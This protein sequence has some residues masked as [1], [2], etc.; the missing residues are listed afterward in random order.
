M[1]TRAPALPS[2]RET[3]ALLADKTRLRL[4]LEL[5]AGERNV[6]DLM[7]AL[8]LPQPVSDHLMLLRE[9]G[10][11]VTRRDGKRV[12]YALGDGVT[13]TGGDG[14]VLACSGGASVSISGAPEAFA[15]TSSNA[16]ASVMW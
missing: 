10:T 8:S 6:S 2:L 7:K 16:G 1:E 11:V 13:G 15:S 4:L 14:L 9:T 12:F 5:G 3:F